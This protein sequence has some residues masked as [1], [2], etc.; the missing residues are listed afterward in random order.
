MKEIKMLE[1]D[2]II[3]SGDLVRQLALEYNGQSDYLETTS[4]YSGGRISRLGWL[5]VNEFMP[6]IIGKTLNEYYSNKWLYPP[7]QLEI[8]RGDVPKSRSDRD[9]A[10]SG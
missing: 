10:R 2:D 9:H 8:V 1:G 4:T 5:T 6:A 3:K 7:S